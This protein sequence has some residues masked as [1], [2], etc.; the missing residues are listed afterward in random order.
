MKQIILPV[1]VGLGLTVVVGGV[2][3]ASNFGD[4]AKFLREHSDAQ[5]LSSADGRAQIIVVPAWQG[6]VMTSTASGEGGASYGWINY[7]LIKRGIAPE[8][9]RQGME[10]HI[11]ALGGEERL[12]LGPEGGQYAIFFKP[13]ETNYAFE[14]W[15]TPALMDTE[16]FEVTAAE[17]GKIS[18]CKTGVLLNNSGAEFKLRVERTVQLLDRATMNKLLGLRLPARV[19]AV[20][21]QTGNTLVNSGATAW[22]A[23]TGALSI[24]LLGMLK[25]G[26]HAVIVIPVRPGS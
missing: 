26:P 18:L 24:W 19:A 1:L 17:A 16:P 4:D 2:Q 6:R 21:Y 5:I 8:D 25:H 23:E 10:K 14:N 7:D 15:K 9:Q 3:A 12:W 20:G 11:Y 22:R 13:G